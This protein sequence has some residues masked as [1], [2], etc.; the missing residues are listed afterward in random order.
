MHKQDKKNQQK[1]FSDV[2]KERM[3]SSVIAWRKVRDIITNHLRIAVYL[4]NA[5]PNPYV[6]ANGAN[7]SR[8][9]RQC[10]AVV[11]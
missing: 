1:I 10:H 6:I 5:I 9:D 2:A 8:F 11:L 3:W 7:R 4:S